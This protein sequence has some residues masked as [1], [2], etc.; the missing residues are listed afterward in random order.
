MWEN[1]IRARRKA[2]KSEEAKRLKNPLKRKI[3]PEDRFKKARDLISKNYSTN[4]ISKIL[5]ISERSVTRFKKRMREEKRKLKAEG[6]FQFHPDDED[7]S[8]KYLSE[9]E[10]LNKAKGYIEKG[11]SLSEIAAICKVS[12]RTVRRWKERLSKNPELTEEEDEE[13][14]VEDPPPREQEE[15]VNKKKRQR[16]IYYDR[17]KV[18]YAVE[19]INNGLSNKEISMFLEL[20]I[21]NVRKLKSNIIN[22]T[23]S[24]IIDDSQYHYSKSN[25]DPLDGADDLVPLPA[26]CKRKPKRTLSD[27]DMHITRILRDKGLRTMDIAKLVNI[28]ER[29]VTRLLTKSKNIEVHEYSI[30]I[31]DEVKEL[32][33]NAEDIVI[34]LPDVQETT[35]NTNEDK[36]DEGLEEVE[37]EV[38]PPSSSFEQNFISKSRIG[39]DLIQMNVK[40]K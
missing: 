39:M 13:T 2:E 24:N 28:S 36:E 35:E 3:S 12:E 8:L 38:D 29:S 7:T 22:G 15:T 26:S 19:L 34:N 30:D 31:L 10:K 6:K 32:L 17:D 14:S 33:R 20:S 11:L 16:K 4:E 40:V 1:S 21:A 25:S 5:K 23:L 18:K 37:E 9:S 27:R